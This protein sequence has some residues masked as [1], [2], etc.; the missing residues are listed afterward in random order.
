MNN[1]QLIRGEVQKSL[2]HNRLQIK[3]GFDKQLAA[4]AST[5]TPA[6]DQTGWRVEGTFKY[7]RSHRF[8]VQILPRY[9]LLSASG[10]P[11]AVG[12]YDVYNL[13]N[14]LQGR[15]RRG[16]WL[17]YIHLT[18]MNMTMPI[19]DTIRF[20]TPKGSDSNFFELFESI[21]GSNRA[22]HAFTSG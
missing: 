19:G 13:Q 12:R 1:R 3:F 15:L 16:R 9:Y 14:T 10:S 4:G 22:T 20:T 7:G 21:N 17:S 2:I 18:N 8:G 6:I 5:T 11:N